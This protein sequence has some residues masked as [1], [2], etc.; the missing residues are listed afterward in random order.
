MTSDRSTFAAGGCYLGMAAGRQA[1]GELQ[2][3]SAEVP[4]TIGIEFVIV[5]AK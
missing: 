2:F 4:A 1:V 5:V 3:R